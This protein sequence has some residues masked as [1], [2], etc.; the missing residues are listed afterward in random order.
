M[1]GLIAVLLASAVV[2]AVAAVAVS[3]ET[4][5]NEKAITKLD[6]R[7]QT[8]YSMKTPCDLMAIDSETGSPITIGS[9]GYGAEDF[10]FSP[11]GILYAS[12]DKHCGVHGGA[13][14]L[15]KIDLETGEGTE[16]GSIGFGDVDAM[17]FAPDG[18]LYA[19]DASTD[20][21]IKI[22]SLTGEGTAV[23]PV[24][25]PFIG[26]IDFSMDSTLFAM[27][28]IWQWRRSSHALNN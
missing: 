22:D 16:I 18:T 8:L 3:A 11:E 27:D 21:L 4:Q 2:V 13:N 12:A 23:G 1:K 14:T 15:I 24:G 17:A 7:T 25:F 6:S 20:Q 5:V 19:V 26:G 9:I 28:N 10:S